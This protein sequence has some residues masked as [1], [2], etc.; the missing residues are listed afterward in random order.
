MYLKYFPPARKFE[1]YSK[2]F[3][4]PFFSGATILNAFCGHPF[5][6]LF[7]TVLTVPMS[8]K[9]P[10]KRPE[11]ALTLKVFDAKTA[12]ASIKASFA[13][14]KMSAGTTRT[15]LIA[16]FRPVLL[17][18]VPKTAKLKCIPSKTMAAVKKQ[19]PPYLR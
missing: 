4:T 13:M 9:G 16:K 17:E 14:I 18:P 12:N 10:A 8:R 3:I 7:K 1:L 2:N 15:N 6:T 11:L 5:A 19:R